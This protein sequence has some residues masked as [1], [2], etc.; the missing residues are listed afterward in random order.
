[1]SK[2]WALLAAALVPLLSGCMSRAPAGPA[3]GSR[4]SAASLPAPS[5]Q[6]PRLMPARLNAAAADGK[7][8]STQCLAEIEAFAEVHTGN[9]VILGQAAFAD[10]DQLVLTRMPLRGADGRLLDGKAAAPQPVVLKL[11]GGPQGCLLQ[12]AGPAV[13]AVPPAAA[14]PAGARDP[15]APASAPLPACSCSPLPG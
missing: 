4:P 8:A 5:A 12:L 15:A 9:R 13:Q 7:G 6:A 3:P 10:S 2:G 14:V 11:A 1:M